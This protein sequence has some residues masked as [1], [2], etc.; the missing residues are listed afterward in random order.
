MA[1]R[2][3]GGIR[4]SEGLLFVRD[5]SLHDEGKTGWV[6]IVIVHSWDRHGR[7]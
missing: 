4:R 1:L 7:S 2:G 5:G 3:V 6:K